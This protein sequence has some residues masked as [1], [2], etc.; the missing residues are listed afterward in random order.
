MILKQSTIRER[1]LDAAIV[2]ARN[3]K[4][5]RDEKRAER[6]HDCTATKAFDYDPCH[7]RLDDGVAFT[8]IDWC[9]NCQIK[10]ALR[11]NRTGN[12]RLRRNAKEQ[13]V[14]LVRLLEI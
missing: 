8:T 12:R 14:R 13:M 6:E 2:F 1:L 3:E 9:E 10:M 11:E 7:A 5:L 4:A